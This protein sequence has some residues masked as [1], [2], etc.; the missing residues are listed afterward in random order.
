[1]YGQGLIALGVHEEKFM[2]APMSRFNRRELLRGLGAAAAFGS[3]ELRP[4]RVRA[5]GE[6]QKAVGAGG[7]LF[8]PYAKPSKVSLVKGNDRR[9]IVY[10]TAMAEAGMGQGDLTKVQVVGTPVE[11][12][13][14][15][16][17]PN[18]KLIESYGLG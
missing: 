10:P 5:E 8:T 6:A 17:K 18:E 9:Q 13:Q 4:G 14:Y 11:Q 3:L 16:F 12:C 1:M 7:R 2:S 15:K